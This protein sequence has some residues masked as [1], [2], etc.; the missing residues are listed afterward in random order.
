[1]SRVIRF[2]LKSKSSFSFTCVSKNLKEFSEKV[3][4]AYWTTRGMKAAGTKF[5]LKDFLKDYTKV[6]IE[7]KEI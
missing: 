1:M 3:E 6:S 5:E 2:A 7:I 4:R